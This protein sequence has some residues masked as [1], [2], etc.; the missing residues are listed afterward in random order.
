MIEK[1]TESIKALKDRK[2]KVNEASNVDPTLC[3]LAEGCV[4]ILEQGDKEIDY[5]F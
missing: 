2:L 1:F 5:I 4:N 3:P